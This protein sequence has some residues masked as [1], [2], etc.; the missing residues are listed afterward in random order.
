MMIAE[1]LDRECVGIKKKT[2]DRNVGKW[3]N[4]RAEKD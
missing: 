2:K 3:P 4:L 1:T